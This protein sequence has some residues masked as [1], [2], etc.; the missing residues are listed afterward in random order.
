MCRYR[1]QRAA[2]GHT[3]LAFRDAFA[4]AFPVPNGFADAETD[5]QQYAEADRSCRSRRGPGDP[6]LPGP[7]RQ[8]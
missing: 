6:E 7:A 1:A 4:D 5:A 3:Q 8:R 2:V